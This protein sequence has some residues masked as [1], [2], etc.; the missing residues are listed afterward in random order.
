LAYVIVPSTSTITAIRETDDSVSR[1]RRSEL[2]SAASSRRELR[3]I[4][5]PIITSMRRS[6]ETAIADPP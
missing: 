4:Q 1:K 5:V 2:S 3:T 6:R